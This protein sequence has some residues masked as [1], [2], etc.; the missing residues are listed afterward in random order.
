MGVSV[1]TSSGIPD[2]LKWSTVAVLLAG[3]V[4]AFYYFGDQSLLLRVIGLIVVGGVAAAVA[5]QTERGREAWEFMRES[6]TELRKVVWPTRKE[7]L[8][9]TLIV[10]AVVALTAVILWIFDGILAWIVRQLLGQGG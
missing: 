8:Q 10:I 9:T 5:L 7:T 6:R 3:S 1:E 2:Q 4:V